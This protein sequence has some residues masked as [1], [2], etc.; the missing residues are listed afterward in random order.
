[1][2]LDI[3][4]SSLTRYYSGNWETIIQQMGRLEGYV[5]HVMRENASLGSSHDSEQIHSDILKWKKRIS[6]AL[7][8][9][10]AAPLNW[11]EEPDAPYFT[12]KPT[13]GCYGDL[14][15]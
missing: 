11:N 2:G 9:K 6:K 5:V 3:Y 12:D 1:M 8:K 14:L 7:Q 10:L 13:W 15:L 4:V